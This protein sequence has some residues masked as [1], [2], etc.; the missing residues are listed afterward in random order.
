MIKTIVCHSAK[1]RTG[2]G[3]QAIGRVGGGGGGGFDMPGSDGL[4]SSCG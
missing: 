2:M 1:V 3:G 4:R